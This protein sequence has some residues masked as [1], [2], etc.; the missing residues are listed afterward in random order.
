MHPLHQVILRKVYIK[1]KCGELMKRIIFIL[2]VCSML[3]LSACSLKTNENEQT[4]SESEQTITSVTESTTSSQVDITIADNDPTNETRSDAES[5]ETTVSTSKIPLETVKPPVAERTQSA[6]EEKQLETEKKQ[7][8]TTSVTQSETAETN[9]PPATATTTE[10]YSKDTESKP[11]V[12]AETVTS[13]PSVPQA[14]AS[15]CALIAEGVVGYIN[16]YRVKE[17]VAAATVLPG[18]TKYAE[19]RSRQL[20]TNFAHDTKDERTAATALLYGEYIDPALYGASGEPYY[21]SNAREAIAK[22]G[23]YGTP[24]E[25]AK[26]LTALVHSSSNHWSYVGSNKYEYIAV[27]VTYEG[28]IWYCNIAVATTSTYG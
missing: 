22:G 11:P 18:L 23:Y 14:T 27:G 25:V 8:E 16:Q 5:K 20:V 3:L 6:T 13:A 10:P 21:R 9:S 17:N 12:E 24:D 2:L 15:D 19:Y 7:P 4:A 1:T 26:K 28:G